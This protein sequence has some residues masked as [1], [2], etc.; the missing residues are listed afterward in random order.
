MDLVADEELKVSMK[1]LV[2]WPT[3]FLLAGLVWAQQPTEPSTPAP[4]PP[5]MASFSPT[6][7]VHPTLVPPV[8][9]TATKTVEPQERNAP[10]GAKGPNPPYPPGR[11]S[12]PP[13]FEIPAHH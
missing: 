12:Y 8:P 13:S 3:L 9:P 6:P 5:P 10:V 4:T 7:Q 11:T 2:F 1:S